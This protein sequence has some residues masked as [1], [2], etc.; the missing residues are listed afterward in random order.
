MAT[1]FLLVGNGA[2]E[3]AIAAALCA[4]KNVC[5]Y[6]YMSARNPGIEALCRSSGGSAALGNIHAPAP[7]A[8]WA[9]KQGIEIAF[10]SPDAVL[11][12]GVSDE[13]IKR[14]IRVAAPTKAASRIE[15]DKA[16]LRQLMEQ[17][18][19]PGCPKYGFFKQPGEL[20]GFIDSLGGQ[21]AVK[22]VGLTGGKGVAVVGY[23]LKDAAEAKAYARAVLTQGIGGAGVI[24][25]EKLEGEEFT[26]Q[27][28]CDGRA[29]I[30]MPAVQD[31]KR[32][33][34][35]DTGPNTGGMGAYSGPG[36][37]LPFL[38][39]AQYDEAFKVMQKVAR[40][41]D[42]EANIR[43][44][45]VMYGQFMLTAKGIYLI[46]INARFGDPEAVN[47]LA[48]LQTP[49]S[50]VFETISHGGRLSKM[51]VKFK[52]EATVVKYLVP[53]GYPAKAVPPSP[54]IVDAKKL[55]SSKAELFYASVDARADG[56]YTASS[57]AL[58]ILGVGKTIAEAEKK[59][60]AGCSAV[61]G[62]VWHRPDIGTKELIEKRIAHIKQLRGK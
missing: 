59:A 51:K 19:I 61:A 55:K 9:L 29:L 20:D 56:L 57:R 58:A 37:L 41:L 8:E 34:V 46:E 2:R 44:S 35:G 38:T 40:I 54:L 52:S 53:T 31:H 23:Q 17:G 18:R 33:N 4:N 15:W 45:G 42:L 28:F 7:I 47:V 62:P 24:I 11:A 32:A 60:E 10:P 50:S 14:G 12:A 6:A 26:L 5:L 25:E 43:F 1:K 36:H 22:P 3:H 30:P 27:A 49:L 16:F 39:Q 48:L 21:V 13:L